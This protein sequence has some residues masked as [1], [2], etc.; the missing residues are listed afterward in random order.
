MVMEDRKAKLLHKKATKKQS[1]ALAVLSKSEAKDLS[2]LVSTQPSLSMIVLHYSN[3]AEEVY[4]LLLSQFQRYGRVETCVLASGLPYG[5]VS[6]RELAAA[7][8]AFEALND[9]E[10]LLEFTPKPHAISL[11]YTSLSYHDFSFASEDCKDSIPVPG[12]SLFSEFISETEEQGLLARLEETPWETLTNRRVQHYGFDFL[13]GR[14]TVNPEAQKGELPVW[15][16]ALVE[17][18]EKV[19]GVRFDQLTVNEYQPGDSIPPHVD[20]HSPFEEPLVSL[21]LSAPISMRFT[22]E[23]EGY[24][25]YLPRRVLVLMTGEAR[26]VWKHA[27]Q[28]KKVDIYKGLASFRS[29]RVSLTFRKVRRI[30]C[31]CP[32][33][34]YCD[35]EQSSGPVLNLSTSDLQRIYVQE[36]YDRIAP[37]F[38]NTR[39]KPWPQVS[40][41]LQTLEPGSVVLDVGCGNGKYLGCSNH[42]AVIGTDR[43]AG[44]LSVARDRGHSVFLA[45]SLQLPICS[46]G[47]DAAISIAVIHHFSTPA[48]RL[49][50]VLELH[51]VLKPNGLAL[52]YVWA[53][54][55]TERTFE[56]Q[57]VLV[58]WHLQQEGEKSEQGEVLQRF[59]HVF[60]QGELEKLV[61]E[62]GLQVARSY[63]DHSNWCVVCKRV[64]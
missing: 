59:Y 49:Q 18:L 41:F 13:Y 4:S 23:E 3:G 19:A 29:R 24:N 64:G 51:R 43:S 5:Y 35:R 56:A 22:K 63:Y 60:V 9:P 8:A 50:A 30:P 40:D 45:N 48:M 61:Q 62:A 2:S 32:F 15:T 39:Y 36:T 7:T 57:D 21:S 25:V 31:N 1:K 12:L 33:P 6:F 42:I 47:V 46:A 37:H 38:S 52:I 26:Y 54:E 28:Q 27:I 14:N 20:S 10:L 44:L 58:P 34:A 16:N 53:K 17:K 11:V 55:Q